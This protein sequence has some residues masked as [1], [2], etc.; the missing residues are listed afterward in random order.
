M[1]NL[2]RDREFVFPCRTGELLQEGQPLSTA[3]YKA[4][5]DLRRESQQ[6][7]SGEE[8]EARDPSPDVET[9]Q[10]FCNIMG[11]YMCRNHVAPKTKLCVPKDDFPIPLND[12]DVQTQTTTSLGVLQ[13]ATMDDY[14]NMDGDKSLSEPWI[15]V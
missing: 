13:E 9:R 10:D 2:K 8:E 4:E 6:I 15:M 12:I 7:S 5:S 11:D 3:V 1:D 14:W